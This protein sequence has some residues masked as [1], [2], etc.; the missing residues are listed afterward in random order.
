VWVKKIDKQI[1]FN[2]IFLKLA[3]DLQKL[4]FNATKMIHR[5]F[6]SVVIIIEIK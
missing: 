6:Y 1:K 4:H 3:C 2:F 5:I